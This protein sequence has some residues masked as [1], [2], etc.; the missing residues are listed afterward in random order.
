M[1]QA[2]KIMLKHI[3]NNEVKM[4]GIATRCYNFQPFYKKV[5]TDD[6]GQNTFL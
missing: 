4:M 1:N 2:M 3:S 6:I 5:L